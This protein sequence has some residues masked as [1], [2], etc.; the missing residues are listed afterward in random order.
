MSS[1]NPRI[2]LILEDVWQSVCFNFRYELSWLE[3]LV[4]RAV[5]WAHGAN[6]TKYVVLQVARIL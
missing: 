2:S 5:P 3:V 4:A 6:P 1:S